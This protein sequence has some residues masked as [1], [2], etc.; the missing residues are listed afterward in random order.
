MPDI[1]YEWRLK[2]DENSSTNSQTMNDTFLRVFKSHFLEIS[3][4]EN[5]ERIFKIKQNLMLVHMMSVDVI[6]K[7]F[8]LRKMN[9]QMNWM[10]N[11]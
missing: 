10:I 7:M 4:K 6:L 1:A 9:F 3:S 5:D 11:K 8:W 2:S